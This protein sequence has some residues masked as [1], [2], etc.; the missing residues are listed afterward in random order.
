[1]K[2]SI[3]II[4][5]FSDL[6]I[7]SCASTKTSSTAITL[8]DALEKSAIEL[9]DMLPQGS[10]V[11][12]VNFDFNKPELSGY[13]IDETGGYLYGSKKLKVV[14][15]KN[16]DLIMKELDWNMSG[17]VS[18]ETAQGIGKMLGAEIIISGALV[19]RGNDYRLRLTAIQTETALVM[20]SSQSIVRNDKIIRNLLATVQTGKE[21]SSKMTVFIDD[22][23]TA[24]SDGYLAY[25]KG[26]YDI[27]ITNFTKAIGL[28]PM[29][30]YAYL[31]R[32]IAYEAKGYLKQALDNINRS[33]E[34]YPKFDRAYFYRG[35]IHAS[36]KNYQMA[37]YD[38]SQA[39]AFNQNDAE[40]YHRRGEIYG[41]LERFDL[42]MADY[43]KSILLKPVNAEV[44]YLRGTAY[45]VRGD[46]NSAIADL[47]KSIEYDRNYVEAYSY[48]A[49]IY[50]L[51]GQFFQ[52]IEDCNQVLKINPRHQQTLELLELIRSRM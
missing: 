39:I 32:G 35:K 20:G 44:Y 46:Y 7:F 9:A 2:K 29:F 19:D 43:N 27:A 36:S 52:A 11:A 17:Y 4:L 16:L 14:T 47:T 22:A 8:N 3:L 18:D 50:T 26:D 31:Y 41:L 6:F 48:R 38:Y 23:D 10:R 33:I 45:S 40:Y 1:M 25:M 51:H 15:R 28:N 49:V 34:L 42:E 5:L 37:I 13:L 30:A 21:V 12:I 24:F